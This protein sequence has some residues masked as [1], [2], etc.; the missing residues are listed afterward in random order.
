MAVLEC[1]GQ[2][3]LA[4][5]GTSVALKVAYGQAIVDRAFDLFEGARGSARTE[6]AMLSC[7]TQM[8]FI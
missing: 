3:V 5:G 4:A 6:C 1:Y 7:V 8:A 2:D